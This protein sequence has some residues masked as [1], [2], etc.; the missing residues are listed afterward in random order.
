MDQRSH[1]VRKTCEFLNKSYLVL[2]ASLQPGVKVLFLFIHVSLLYYSVLWVNVSLAFKKENSLW[3]GAVPFLRSQDRIPW[4]VRVVMPRLPVYPW[5][6]P[7]LFRALAS[8]SHSRAVT[9]VGWLK[10]GRADRARVFPADLSSEL[11]E[12]LGSLFTSHS[13]CFPL[14]WPACHIQ[15]PELMNTSR[16]PGDSL[17][18]PLILQKLRA[19]GVLILAQRS[20][21]QSKLSA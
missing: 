2:L 4:G 8:T 20:L 6:K 9:Q 13:L 19:R 11:W 17:L 15:Q 5:R 14:P 12:Q 21:H 10:K 3:A 18:K 7:G 1:E 16:C